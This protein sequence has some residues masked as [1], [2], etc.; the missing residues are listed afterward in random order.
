MTDDDNRTA[1]EPAQAAARSGFAWRRLWPLAVLALGLAAAKLTGL[2]AHLTFDALKENRTALL[3]LVDRHGALAV[4]VFMLA[5][6]AVVAFSLPGG[7][8]MTLAG[9]FLF[10]HVLAT[11]YVVVAATAG[12]TLLFLAAR[13]AL[14]EPLAAKAGPWLGRMRAGF[15]ENALSYMLFLRLIPAFPFF[16]VN[17]VPAF[18]GMRLGPYILGTALGIV[19]GTFVYA[20][21]GDGLGAILDRGEDFTLAAVMTPE[22]VTA[23]VGLGVL[24]LLPVA[25]K[26]WRKR[27]GNHTAR[28][29][30]SG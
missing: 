12:A 10:G 9:G 14:G 4:A 7:A 29:R 2:D 27:R 16:V 23:L 5:Y 15:N 24:S 25:Y 11:L 30:R 28:N 6:V 13:T 20:T 3:D 1:A 19:P 8:V 26:H 21:F 17:L 22:I 18:L